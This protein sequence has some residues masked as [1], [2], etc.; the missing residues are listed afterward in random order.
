M[1]LAEISND[2]EAKQFQKGMGNILLVPIF[3]IV[4]SAFASLCGVLYWILLMTS[5]RFALVVAGCIVMWHVL[6]FQVPVSFGIQTLY[7]VSETSKAIKARESVTSLTGQEI[8]HSLNEFILA[9]GGIDKADP[10]GFINYL[11]IFPDSAASAGVLGSYQLHKLSYASIKCAER[12]FD[13]FMQAHVESM[14]DETTPLHE[15]DI[16]V[17]YPPDM[18]KSASRRLSQSLQISTRNNF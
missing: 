13:V 5:L 1:Q 8:S 16:N 18:S 6:V 14:L 17:N 12:M 11:S 3:S 7:V 2:V 15:G 10:Q 4:M 9:V